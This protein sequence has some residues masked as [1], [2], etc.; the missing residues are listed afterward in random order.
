MDTRFFDCS[1][2]LDFQN[3]EAVSFSS[4]VLQNNGL[5]AF[6]TET[7][8]GLGANGLSEIAVRKIF[9]AKGRPLDNPLI[10]HISDFSQLE[11]LVREIPFHAILLF[12]K[13]WPGALT[14]VFKKS[15]IVPDMISCGL[16]TVAIRMPSHDLA[17]A[18]IYAAGIPIAA[19]SANL[20]GR[21]SPT[22]AEHVRQDLFGK[23]DVLIDG[24]ATQIGIESTVVDVSGSVPVLLRPGMISRG[25]IESVVGTI[26]VSSYSEKDPVKSPGMKYKHYSPSARVILVE[27]SDFVSRIA[28]F[29]LYQ[30]SAVVLTTNPER[31][32]QVPTFFLGNSPELCAQNLFFAYRAFDQQGVSLILIEPLGK[33]DT[34]AGVRNRVLKS[35]SEV[36]N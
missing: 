23:I 25:E 26:L 8:Y 24:G 7:V 36:W 30:K 17:R 22:L 6:P 31:R 33:D 4:Q 18:L 11:L 15:E 34:W 21:S 12:E 35:V 1:Q 13:F 10:L 29:L 19:P 32:Y 16:D 14:L 5:V 28:E 20:S 27:S 9:E 3:S 2:L